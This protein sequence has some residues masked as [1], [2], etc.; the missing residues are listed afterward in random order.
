MLSAKC[1]AHSMPVERNQTANTEKV[2][3]SQATG[4]NTAV[5]CSTTAGSLWHITVYHVRSV[6]GNID[7][8][9]MIMAR[10]F[11]SVNK[12]QWIFWGPTQ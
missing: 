10:E 8:D 3:A 2:A 1:P 6:R 11:L 5:A 9:R 12:C 4:T 7:L